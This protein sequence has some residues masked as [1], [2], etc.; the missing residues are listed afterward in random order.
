RGIVDQGKLTAYGRA[1]EAMP[2]ERAWAELLVNADDDLIPFLTVMSAIESLHRMTREERD[3]EGVLIPGSDHM[4]AYAL[5]A[6][7]YA[8]AGTMGEVYGLPRHIFDEEGITR[9]ADRRGALVKS[10]EDAA[11]GMASVYRGIGLPLP[12]RMPRAN[13]DVLRRFQ[14]LLARFMPFT[15]VI[16]EETVSGEPA[17]VSK[18]SV[19]GSWGAIAGELRYFA[20]KFGT[21]RA[22]IEG[23]QVP[24]DLLRR[25][26]RVSEPELA[27]EAH[28]KGSPLVLRRRATYFGFELEREV[29]A[30]DEFPPELAARARRV[31]A[32]ALA[33]GDA[34]HPGVRANQR[35]V[36]EVRETYRRSGG[37]TPRLG[38]SELATLYEAQL[39]G[40]RSIS[41]FQR[42]RVVI[43]PD[44]IVPAEVRERYRGL[45]AS[46]SVRGRDVEIQYDVEETPEGVTG[47]ARLRLPEKMAR[48][49]APDELPAL[50]RP[51]RFVVARGA[52]GAARGATLD[53]LQEELDRPFTTEEIETLDRHWEDRRR[54]QRSHQ[55][56]GRG[57]SPGRRR[58]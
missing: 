32:E 34:R 57:R 29:E 19:C 22:S 38:A 46:V 43:D 11:L 7:A 39:Q 21:P 27:F 2:A 49:L 26:A 51:L 55:R 54:Q 12:A 6:E 28:R 13:D 9:W 53:E 45:P 58:H 47:V 24:M 48:T 30:V 23:T 40:V 25:H 18:R 56:H 35:A 37:V 5:Y 33:R 4:T 52:R 17:R 44:A 1:V 20:D 14:E 8:R 16:D 50:D 36:D 41:D 15:L 42:A 3:L 31:L 10:I